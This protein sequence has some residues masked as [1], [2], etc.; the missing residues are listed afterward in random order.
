MDARVLSNLKLEDARAI[1]RGDDPNVELP[2]LETRLEIMRQHGE[3]L[4]REY[5]GSFVNCIKACEG[6]AQAL[7]NLV[8][9]K[10]PSFRD[11]AVYKGRNGWWR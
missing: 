1:F 2:L 7:L 5:N 8:C 4:L 10:F 3:I 9:E 6:S 11:K